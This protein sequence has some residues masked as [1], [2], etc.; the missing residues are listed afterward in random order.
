MIGTDYKMDLEGHKNRFMTQFGLTNGGRYHKVL[1]DKSIYVCRY[2][3]QK[4]NNEKPHYGTK[5]E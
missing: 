1:I 5:E 2:R 4:T 3:F